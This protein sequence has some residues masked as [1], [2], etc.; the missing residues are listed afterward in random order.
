MNKIVADVTKKCYY[1]NTPNYIYNFISTL[2]R[3]KNAAITRTRTGTQIKEPQRFEPTVT[4]THRGSN[5][6]DMKDMKTKM[7]DQIKAQHQVVA[8]GRSVLQTQPINQQQV[9]S[10]QIFSFFRKRV[11]KIAISELGPVPYERSGNFIGV[12]TNFQIPIFQ[13]KK[14]FF[15]FH[16]EVS[17]SQKIL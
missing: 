1:S 9:Q 11:V 5:N 17:I 14:R 4:L 10:V 8:G 13:K 16:V 6:T 7:D 3:D 12:F 2:E 15:E